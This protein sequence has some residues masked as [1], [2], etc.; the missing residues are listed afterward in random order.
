MSR[1]SGK[2]ED[3]S[4][5]ELEKV[6]IVIINEIDINEIIHEAQKIYAEEQKKGITESPVQVIDEETD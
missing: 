3:Y 5:N 1:K 2:S 4:A 6:A